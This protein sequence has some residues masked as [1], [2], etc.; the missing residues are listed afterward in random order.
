VSSASRPAQRLSAITWAASVV[1]EARQV[2]ALLGRRATSE[3]GQVLPFQATWP[4]MFGRR[5]W[6]HQLPLRLHNDF[7][8]PRPGRLEEA[9]YNSNITIDIDMHHPAGFCL[10]KLTQ[11]R[12]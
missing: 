1:T 11:Y 12:L 10:M 3:S 9:L 4:A 6:S 2:S 8:L 7:D 5:T